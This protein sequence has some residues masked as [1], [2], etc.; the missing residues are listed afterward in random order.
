ML[1]LV[2]VLTVIVALVLS[3]AG[4]SIA[5]NSIEAGIFK[6]SVRE[7]FPNAIYVD[8]FILNNSG[9]SGL[10]R[11]SI[12]FYQSEYRRYRSDFMQYGADKCE[13][14][15]HALEHFDVQI[16]FAGTNL[17]T[18]GTANVVCFNLPE[19]NKGVAAPAET[20][21]AKKKK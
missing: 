1:K 4:D 14:Q 7:V 20:K 12:D 3:I 15:Y 11:S 13:T 10:S 17:M 5:G 21:P 9:T 6:G 2:K 8:S 16:A 19:K 18:V